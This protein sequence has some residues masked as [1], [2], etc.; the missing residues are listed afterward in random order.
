M[1]FWFGPYLGS[2]AA[3]LVYYQLLRP[4]TADAED[5]PAKP[6]ATPAQLTSPQLTTPQAVFSGRAV[7]GSVAG[8]GA[9]AES[10]R[11]PVLRTAEAVDVTT[12]QAM[13]D[14]EWR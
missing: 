4:P 8:A 12:I 14:D 7:N 10:D 2:T 6:P 3:A 13:R 1:Q 11:A 5:E 9:A